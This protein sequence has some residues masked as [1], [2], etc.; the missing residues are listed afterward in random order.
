VGARRAHNPEVE[1]SKPSP[2][3]K[4]L[5]G[6]TFWMTRIALRLLSAGLVH[7][8]RSSLRIPFIQSSRA[9]KA[10][11]FRRLFTSK[12]EESMP[13]SN[14]GIVDKPED[15]AIS[16]MQD[17]YLRTLAEMEN[18]RNR[19]RREVEAAHQFAVQKFIRDLLPVADT[20]ELAHASTMS[21]AD[22]GVIKIREG[23]QMTMDEL[24]KALAAHGVSV[25]DPLHQK[26]DPNLHQAVLE[27]SID[28][29]QPGLITEVHKKGYLLHG[30][31]VRAAIVSIA[32]SP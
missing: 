27:V 26:F 28:G 30:R 6:K 23:L 29:A 31:V 13:T 10:S 20:L 17:R 16:Q 7:S 21:F 18:L 11:A 8:P 32:K 3:N 2:A 9:S 22:D 19:T 1:G 25:I 4:F 14:G 12:T 15:E 24:R 5:S